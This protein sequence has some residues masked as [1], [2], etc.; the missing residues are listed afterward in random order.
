VTTPDEPVRPDSEQPTRRPSPTSRARRIGG[1]PTPRP[2]K[3]AP[4]PRPATPEPPTLSGDEPA[5]PKPRPSL[6]KP[7][8]SPEPDPV[9]VPLDEQAASAGTGRLRWLPAGILG[10][11]VV[12]LLVVLVIASHGV[13]WAKS[14]TSAGARNAYQEQV[15]SATKKCFATVNTYDY[16]KLT[17]LV[18]RDVACAT[19]KFK[20]DLQTALQKTILPQAPKLKAVQTA[21][22]NK[23]GIVSVTPD[24][25][26][27]TTLIYGQLTQSNSTTAKQSPR[28]DLFGAVVTVDHVG[29]SWLI[30]KVDF[31]TGNGLGS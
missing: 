21:Q 31:D 15:L 3:P 4:A 19:G 18:P 13:Y 25:K 2:A 30:A 8:V 11:A 24:G 7:V 20:T 6:R 23:A 9:V 22:V 29:K 14:T 17:G 5:A 10:I 28:T 26:Q 1:R 12:A 16:R 27:W